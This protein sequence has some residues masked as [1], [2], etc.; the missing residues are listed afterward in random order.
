MWLTK[1]E[2]YNLWGTKANRG[3]YMSGFSSFSIPDTS[4]TI[5]FGLVSKIFQCW[6]MNTCRWK[7]RRPALLRGCRTSSLL[8][9]QLLNHRYC[10][11]TRQK[12]QLIPTLRSCFENTSVSP[13]W[14]QSWENAA[15]SEWGLHSAPMHCCSDF[16]WKRVEC[17]PDI[18]HLYNHNT[19]DNLRNLK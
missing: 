12:L 8:M 15:G 17:Q 13:I 7:V 9:S 11:S 3:I 2:H 14:C 19:Q 16:A 18:K 1:K 4:I 5:P 10:I 6:I